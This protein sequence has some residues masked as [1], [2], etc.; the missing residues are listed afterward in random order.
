V[1]KENKERSTVKVSPA[2]LNVLK[3]AQYE[4]RKL[5]GIEPTYE[6]LLQEWYTSHAAAGTVQ[7]RPAMQAAPSDIPGCVPVPVPPEL[8][9]LVQQF[10]AF[11]QLSNTDLENDFKAYVRSVLAAAERDHG[12]GPYS[13]APAEK[14]AKKHA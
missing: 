12:L 3:D 14:S 5:T 4:R 9:H 6:E 10:V 1:A 13:T 11:M 7:H 2:F 8:V